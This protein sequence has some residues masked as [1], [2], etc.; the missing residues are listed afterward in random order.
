VASAERRAVGVTFFVNGVVSGTFASRLPWIA[1]R[2]HL[3][4]GTLGLVGLA[5]SVGALVTMPFAAQFVHRYGPKA[6][7]RVLIVAFSAAL[8]LPAVA[9]DLLV[10]AAVMLIFGALAGINDNAM[11]AQAIEAERRIGRSIMSGL[12]GLWSLGVLGG[13]LI[14]SLVRARAPESGDPVRGRGHRGGRGRGRG[15]SLVRRPGAGRR[16]GRT[17]GATVR[18]A[19]RQALAHRACRLRGHLRGVRRE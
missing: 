12:H 8:V 5:T 6:T 11:N 9:P 19:A 10:L 4:S 1:G 15:V 13:A 16:G 7:T 18:L 17:A 2:L 3:S 14:G